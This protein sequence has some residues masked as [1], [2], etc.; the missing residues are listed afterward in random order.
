MFVSSRLRDAG[1]PDA[2]IDPVR[3]VQPSLV[4]SEHKDSDVA[5]IYLSIL[6][7][8]CFNSLR[9]PI[10][11]VNHDSQLQALFSGVFRKRFHLQL[12]WQRSTNNLQSIVQRCQR[13]GG[14]SLCVSDLGPSP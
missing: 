10:R 3:N 5:A 6:W 12:S 11:T 1:H 7:H 14:G 9:S 2:I 4:S 8:P 13:E